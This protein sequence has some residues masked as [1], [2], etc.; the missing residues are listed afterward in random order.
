[1]VGS[2]FGALQAVVG[3]GASGVVATGTGPVSVPVVIGSAEGGFEFGDFTA[4]T[5]A[6]EKGLVDLA[7]EDGQVYGVGFD[8]RGEGTPEQ[9]WRI[10][11]RFDGEEW[12]AIES[13]CGSCAG[14]GFRAVAAS[15]AELLVG[16]S[17]M[18][19]SSAP[20][21]EHAWLA[22]W[23]EGEWTTIEVP[24]ADLVQ[25]I[26]DI[27]VASDG[28]VYFAAGSYESPA[29]L[30]SADPGQAPVIEWTRPGIRLWALTETADGRILAAGLQPGPQQGVPIVVERDH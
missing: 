20:V 24:D 23:S 12:G 4:G 3:F 27:L 21:T 18:V 13:P 11:S 7:V 25:Q 5:S 17:I 16:G 29:Y 1:V 22:S 10:V 26:N 9:P 30:L 19:D 14:I 15:A 8:D 2:S 6:G 28:T